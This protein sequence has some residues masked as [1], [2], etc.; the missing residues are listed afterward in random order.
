[1]PYEL[2]N[3]EIKFYSIDYNIFY[4]SLMSSPH[5]EP[6]ASILLTIYEFYRNL[7]KN[8]LVIK[9]TILNI[10]L[11]LLELIFMSTLI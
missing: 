2:Y 9:P 7:M 10:T 3:D 6:L 8:K 11:I 4:N 1:M 5:L